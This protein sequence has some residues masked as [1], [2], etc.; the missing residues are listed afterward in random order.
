MFL[1]F[2]NDLEDNIMSVILKFVDDTKIF[3]KVPMQ[4]MDYSYN[5]IWTGFVIG[6]T[7][8]RWS[9][10]SQSTRPCVLATAMAE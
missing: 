5:R 1:I 10:I 2:I 4:R 7:N 9:S 3:R 6:L 8:G